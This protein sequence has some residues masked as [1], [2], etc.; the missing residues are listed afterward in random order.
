MFI[1]VLLIMAANVQRVQ[2]CILGHKKG[3]SPSALPHT[4]N[5]QRFMRQAVKINAAGSCRKESLN[6][7]G[8]SK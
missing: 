4:S 1:L 7:K 3:A 8:S 2:E 5:G 6:F